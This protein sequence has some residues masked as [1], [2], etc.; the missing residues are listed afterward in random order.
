MHCPVLHSEK[1]KAYLAT[2]ESTVVQ[3]VSAG[4]SRDKS[5]K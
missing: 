3:L 5:G 1:Y 2:R 4:N